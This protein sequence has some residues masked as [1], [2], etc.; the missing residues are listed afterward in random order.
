MP[1]TLGVKWT[2]LVCCSN[3]CKPL[4]QVYTVGPEG[5]QNY[6]IVCLEIV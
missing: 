3:G 6:S 1:A 2:P 4:V 5:E